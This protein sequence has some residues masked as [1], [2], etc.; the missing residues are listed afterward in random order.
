MA[1]KSVVNILS[2]GRLRLERLPLNAPPYASQ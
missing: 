2:D 1:Q